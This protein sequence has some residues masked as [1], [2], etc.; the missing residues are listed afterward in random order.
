MDEQ[1]TDETTTPETQ[2]VR[3]INVLYSLEEQITRQTSLKFAFMRGAIYG[4]GTVVGAT[5]LIALFGGIL[6][7]TIDSLSSLPLIGDF[8]N[9]DATER[10]TQ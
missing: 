4:I 6:A 3:L 7:A 10:L 8:V 1:T 9:E 2:Q 5:L